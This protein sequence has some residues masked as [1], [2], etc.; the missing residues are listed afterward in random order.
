MFYRK[1]F[2]KGRTV[3]I[4]SKTTI[5]LSSSGCDAV[6]M[7]KTT[8]YIKVLGAIVGRLMAEGSPASHTK[9]I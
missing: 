5:N 6:D 3:F 2:R 9:A 4:R 1:K 7:L 8:I